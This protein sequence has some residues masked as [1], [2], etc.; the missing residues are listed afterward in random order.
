M[1]IFYNTRPIC[2]R[3]YMSPSEQ[4]H[5]TVAAVIEQNGRF[6]MIEEQVRG[7]WLLN[8]PAGHVQAGET[9]LE[10]VHRETREEAASQIQARGLVCMLQWQAQRN[11]EHYLRIVFA[12]DFISSLDL[13]LDDGIRATHW[14]T[15]EEIKNH[16]LKTRNPAVLTAI[17]HYL[18]G[19]LYP[20]NLLESV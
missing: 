18:A 3:T 16:K 2:L 5:L 6:L 17:E 9:L 4:P 12:A 14:L 13:P 11:Q 1:T 7:V 19:Q 20:L 8:Q 15:L 10:A